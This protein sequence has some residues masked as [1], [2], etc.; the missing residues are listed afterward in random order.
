MDTVKIHNTQKNKNE[1]FENEQQNI[2]KKDK[3]IEKITENP[4]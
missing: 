2:K 1:I 3:K 4:I